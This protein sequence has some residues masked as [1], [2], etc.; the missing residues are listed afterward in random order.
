MNNGVSS[1]KMLSINIAH[2]HVQ[3]RNRCWWITQRTAAKQATVQ[4]DY[5]VASFKSHRYEYRADVAVV[6][7]NQNSHLLNSMFSKGLDLV[8]KA[9]SA[10]SYLEVYPYTAKTIRA[11]MPSTVRHERFVRV[12]LTPTEYRHL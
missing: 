7:R 6:S 11:C 3:G 1:L 12:A 2:V 8:P 10:F 4:A 5:V 9:C